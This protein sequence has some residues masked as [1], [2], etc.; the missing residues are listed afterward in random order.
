[1]FSSQTPPSRFVALCVRKQSAMIGAVDAERRVVLPARPI[2]LAELDCWLHEHLQ[3]TDAVVVESPANTWHL[4]DQIAQLAASV[5]IAHPQLANLLPASSAAVDPRDTINLARMHAGGLVP[6]LWVPPAHVRDARAL[7]AHRRRLLSQQADARQALHDLL[8]R[9]GLTPPG[10]DRLG[11]DRRDWWESRD[12]A[13]ADQARMRASLVSLNR[14]PPLLEGVEREL[15]LLS[16]AAP[17][18]GVSERLVRLPGM[19]EL[20]AVLL[21]GAIGEIARF[22][23]PAQLVGY[24]GLGGQ[25]APGGEHG[26]P[27]QDGN[28]AKEGRREIRAVMLDVAWAAVHADAGRRATFEALERRIGRGRAIAATARKLL[29]EVW[30]T[31][32]VDAG[33]SEEASGAKSVALGARQAA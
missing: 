26:E 22:P 6:A 3:P 29:V 8:R 16:N 27:A 5:T 24:A 19:S 31:L 28:R 7:T 15:A 25:Q 10:A 33:L 21:L 13:P 4:H 23:A 1:M 30:D 12:L 9:Y 14:V 17:W 11:A 20:N 32:V 2:V 18:R